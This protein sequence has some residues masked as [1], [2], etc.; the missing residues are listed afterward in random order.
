MSDPDLESRIAAVRRFNRFYTR[1]LGVLREGLLHT[2]HSPTEARILYEVAKGGLPTAADLSRGLGL[3]PGYLSRI[4][5]SL[6]QQGL[7]ERTRS[8]ADARQ[9][10]L[11][12]TTEGEK[13][14]AVLD[15]RSREEVRDLLAEL[16]EA[17]Q[18]RL[19]EAMR[20]IEAIIDKELK[21]AN[22]YVLRPPGPGD[23][24][25]VI[26]RHGALYAEEYGW[27]QEF[28]ALVARIVADFVS[29]HD[30]E[31]ERCW[32]AEMDGE[33]VGS[34]FV[35]RESDAVAKLRLLL[36]EP[37]TRGLGIGRRL[38]EECIRFAKRTGYQTMT[39]W[40]NNVLVPARRLYE[41]LG[42]RLVKEE[43]H[44]SFGPALIGETWERPL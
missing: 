3:D 42:F 7:I 25:W 27:N 19:V 40:T 14:F 32:I 10:L 12:L 18:R 2:P 24:G 34:V 23:M 21:F 17:E 15:T 36:V 43:P 5:A 13:A 39:L 26:Q 38:V 20:T 44:R 22:P 33:P 8:E 30:P 35:V 16:S 9:R 1:T 37:K 31:K 28:E 41:K 6:E 11:S 4:L 29:G